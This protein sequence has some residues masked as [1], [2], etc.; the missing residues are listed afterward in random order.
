MRTKRRQYGRANWWAVAFLAVLAGL[1][2]YFFS[3]TPES[4]SE[5][6]PGALTAV[7]GFFAGLLAG[8]W[9]VAAGAGVVAETFL[10]LLLIGPA[11]LMFILCERGDPR[12]NLWWEDDRDSVP[13]SVTSYEITV[14]VI[15]VATLFLLDYGG[16]PIWETISSAAWYEQLAGTILYVVIGLGWVVYRWNDLSRYLHQRSGEDTRRL[17]KSIED[18]FSNILEQRKEIRR[19]FCL[20][21]NAPLPELPD[22]SETAYLAWIKKYVSHLKISYGPAP[23]QHSV[24][25]LVRLLER[26]MQS[27]EVAW[28]VYLSRD[29]SNSGYESD[30]PDEKLEIWIDA[31]KSGK[32]LPEVQAFLEVEKGV[33][34]IRRVSSGNHKGQLYLWTTFWPWSMGFRILRKVLTLKIFRDLIRLIANAIFNLMHG[35]FD[36]IAARH[37]VHFEV[38]TYQPAPPSPPSTDENITPIREKAQGGDLI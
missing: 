19:E 23:D 12:N 36:R 17:L 10:W 2:W 26:H 1:A 37:E 35:V 21:P 29:P 24:K 7:T 14:S 32:I 30:I 3:I 11:I 33:G 18:C 31:L 16:I 9:F 4:A 13:G 25:E 38:A 6:T 15:C 5:S 34:R 27:C 8:G 20:A 22:P 28:K